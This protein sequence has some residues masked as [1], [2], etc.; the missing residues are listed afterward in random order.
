MARESWLSS[1][2]KNLSN[3]MDA[4]ADADPLIG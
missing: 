4:R 3:I 2:P 1:L